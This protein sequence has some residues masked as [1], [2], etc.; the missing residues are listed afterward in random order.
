[1]HHLPLRSAI[2][3]LFVAVSSVYLVE[4]FRLHGANTSWIYAFGC[5]LF[6]LGLVRMGEYLVDR[7]LNQVLPGGDDAYREKLKDFL[8]HYYG[9]LPSLVLLDGH[10]YFRCFGREYKMSPNGDVVIIEPASKL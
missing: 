8:Q 5:F 1:M 2:L 4:S 7:R 10:C 3:W 9:H 6:A